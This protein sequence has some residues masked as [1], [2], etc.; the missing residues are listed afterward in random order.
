MPRITTRRFSNLFRRPRGNDLSAAIPTLFRAVRIGEGLAHEREL[1]RAGVAVFAGDFEDGAVV[2]D[3]AERAVRGGE[4]TPLSIGDGDLHVG[5]WKVGGAVDYATGHDAAGVGGGLA[6][7]V[8]RPAE[9][10]LG[11][12]VVFGPAQTFQDLVGEAGAEAAVRDSGADLT[13]LRSTLTSSGP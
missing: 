13:I 9:G 11:Q 1:A 3:D 4:C 6:V 5:D 2:L 10:V 7:P 8:E 12:L